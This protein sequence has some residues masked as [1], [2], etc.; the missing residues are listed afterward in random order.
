M[1]LF[2]KIKTVYRL[3]KE[4]GLDI[5]TFD[6]LFRSA[7]LSITFIKKYGLKSFSVFKEKIGRYRGTI[8]VFEENGNPFANYDI[9]ARKKYN[10]RLADF[11]K[12]EKLST[13]LK[14]KPSISAILFVESDAQ[15]EE[16]CDTFMSIVKQAYAPNQIIVCGKT[17]LHQE[18][19]IYLGQGSGLLF[20]ESLEEAI[21]KSEADYILFIKTGDRLYRNSFFEIRA[22]FNADAQKLPDVLFFDHDYLKDGQRQ[23][24]YFKWNYN[25]ELLT[26]SNYIERAAVFKMATLKKIASMNLV[27]DLNLFLYDTQLRISETGSFVHLPGVYMSIKMDV[28][29]YNEKEEEVRRSFFERMNIDVDIALNEYYMPQITYKVKKNPKVAIIIPTI[30]KNDLYRR[31]IETIIE[32]TT[33]SNYE[34]IIVDNTRKPEQ[35]GKDKMKGHDKCRLIYANEPF[36]WSKLNNMAARSSDAE[37]YVFLN[38]DTEIITPQWLDVMVADAQRDEIGMVGPLL[39]FPN[40]TVQSAGVFLVDH[41]GGGRSYFLGV[42]KNYE[43]YFNLLHL[44][45][46]CTFVIGACI[47]IEKR[48]FESIG[49]FDES[50]PLVGNEM[51][52]GLRLYEK[53]Y[54]NVYIPEAALY[55]KE[56]ASRA[57]ISEA[58]ADAKIWKGIGG[59]LIKGDPYYNRYLKKELNIPSLEYDPTLTCFSNQYSLANLNVKKI[60]IIKLDHIGDVMLTISSIRQ[61]RKNF[62]NA[63]ITLLC[64]PWM[65]SIMQMQPEIDEIKTYS[66]FDV[67]SQLGVR[68]PEKG[69]YEALLKELKGEYF[70]LSI[71]MRRHE[72]TKEIA[73]QVADY[74]L[75]YSTDA[76]HEEKITNPIPSVRDYGHVSPRLS[77]MEQAEQLVGFTNARDAIRPLTLSQATI[78]S[79]NA[80]IA[81]E[82]LFQ[83]DIVVGIHAGA[84]GYFKCWDYEKFAALADFIAADKK[85][86]VLL[87]GGESEVALNQKIMGLMKHKDNVASIAATSTLPEFL[88]V[89]KSIDYFIGNDSGPKHMAG[90]QGCAVLCING[91]TSFVEWAPPGEKSLSVRRSMECSPC[92]YYLKEQCPDRVCLNKLNPWDVYKA[93][94]RL[95]LFYPPE[96]R[97]AIEAIPLDNVVEAKKNEI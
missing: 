86:A 13:T 78:D 68:T 2:R 17:D 23:K 25:R 81:A 74:C 11:E 39:L 60:L 54:K 43:G 52:F 91:S 35:Y 80:K 3:L 89:L 51:N 93:F 38:D 82:P 55:H 44:R 75:T 94:E 26:V 19:L 9:I 8:P 92:Y 95:K 4:R 5:L 57:H 24:P 37:I 65:K 34:I 18:R 83:K 90:I 6:G 32:K 73:M 56:K 21:S 16:V 33:Y 97:Q 46:E 59:Y 67:K 66:Y 76:E 30:F 42:P 36:N 96:K 1:A 48:K 27:D 20:V 64:G 47:V 49:G 41:G 84:G 29:S 10:V 87:L 50:F 71:H 88:H 22:A 31:C 85:C 58:Q 7:K 14:N 28:E 45:R 40:D 72:E 15:T 53:G 69:E 79:A 12:M 77:F 63:H 62:P 61:V 70:D